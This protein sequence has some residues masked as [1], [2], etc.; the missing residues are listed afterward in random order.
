MSKFFESL[1]NN[2]VVRLGIDLGTCNTLIHVQGKGI[3]VQEPSVVAISA[4]NP[5]RL[6]EKGQEAR[7]MIGRAPAGVAAIRPLQ[8][9][10]IADFDQAERML[11]LYIAQALKKRPAFSIH[12]AI[13]APC[14]VNEVERLAIIEAV[15]KAGARKV[16]LLAAPLAAALGA[17]IRVGDSKGFGVVDIGGGTTEVAII[18]TKGIVTSGSIKI[19]GN[20]FD[21]ALAE[22]LRVEHKILVGDRT[23][24][25]AKIDIGSVL[26]LKEEMIYE[27]GGRD[28]ATGLPRKVRITSEEARRALQKPVSLLIDQISSVFE[29]MPPELASDLLDNGILLAGGGSLLRGIDR[30]I[31]KKT[32]MPTHL[33][34]DP[35]CCVAHGA[36]KF[37]ALLEKDPSIRDFA[38]EEARFGIF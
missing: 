27:I 11:R 5:A 33:A 25:D 29:T 10:V 36:G 12:V 20:T 26:P 38:M 17:G 8:D 24:E 4:I 28:M 16:Y 15:R 31:S 34:S 23:V 7:Q 3:L 9:G 14:K 19:A 13:S 18:S 32:G 30:L 35:F 2:F 1:T 22:Y 21:A 6:I 37:L